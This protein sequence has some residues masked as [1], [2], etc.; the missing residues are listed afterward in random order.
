MKYSRFNCSKIYKLKDSLHICCFEDI[1][2]LG[3][4]C[5]NRCL[6]I[7]LSKID[8][9]QK[10]MWYNFIQTLKCKVHKKV[11]LNLML[12]MDNLLNIFHHKGNK[13]SHKA[14]IIM[15]FGYNLH[16]LIHMDNILDCR[17]YLCYK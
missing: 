4:E 11:H 14:D 9:S 13:K 8:M 7:H 16:S 6:I 12:L 17:Q 3:M 1:F 2:L 10:N 5:I 15:K